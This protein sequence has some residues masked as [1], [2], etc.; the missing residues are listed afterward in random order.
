[1]Y[2]SNF[3][4]IITANH[5]L[6]LKIMQ[7]R[8]FM[9][10]FRN[11]IS[12]VL[13]LVF[14]GGINIF[15][16]GCESDNS[17]IKKLGTKT[18]K[19]WTILNDEEKVT[20]QNFVIV[21][22]SGVRK[23]FLNTYG[24]PI[25]NTPFI[26][27]SP[28]IQY[29]QFVSV[30]ADVLSSIS[31]TFA[32]AESFPSFEIEQNIVSLANQL[33]YQSAWLTN[34]EDFDNSHY[35]H[36]EIASYSHQVEW[37]QK[38]GKHNDFDLIDPFKN[39]IQE[40]KDKPNFIVL[41]TNGSSADACQNIQ[42]ETPD[43]FLSKTLSCYVESIREM[44]RLLDE[45]H[46]VLV[47]TNESFTLIYLSDHGLVINEDLQL[48]QGE[49]IREVYEVPLLV[50]MDEINENQIIESKRVSNDFLHLFSELNQ[51]KTE[52]MPRNYSYL[53]NDMHFGKNDFV[54]DP[55]LNPVN[56]RCLK[57]NSIHSILKQKKHLQV[58]EL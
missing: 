14:I 26:S 48:E 45:V 33:G 18:S 56:Q 37:I 10:N 38:E 12:G 16:T 30:G 54:L 42:N 58:K 20:K 41:H 57:T 3:Y 43:F 44:D 47:N 9:N 24:F 34:R 13:F 46:Q 21:L 11:V 17:T 55:D 39:I 5:S 4:H 6:F 28:H 23:D 8:T 7:K 50:W 36:G 31:R 40:G 19:A 51:I 15:M 2:L 35:A 49:F 32:L 22:G 25:E 29:E 1:M 53:S 27:H 52:E